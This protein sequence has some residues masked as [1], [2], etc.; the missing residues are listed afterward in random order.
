MNF[1]RVFNHNRMFGFFRVKDSSG[2]NPR[3]NPIALMT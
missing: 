3:L 1:E 2:Y